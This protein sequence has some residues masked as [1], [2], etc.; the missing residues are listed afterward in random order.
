M[1]H[2]CG[3]SQ[4]IF[5]NIL[6]VLTLLAVKKKK[7]VY[8][9]NTGVFQGSKKLPI[10]F[11]IFINNLDSGTEGTLSKFAD[12]TELG[13]VVDTPH[14]C[15]AIQRELDELE[16]QADISSSYRNEKSCS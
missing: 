13:R 3:P 7:K 2:F 9:K 1:S 14:G 15:A 5:V 12:D 11:N 8:Q 10:F 6:H 4:V 16:K